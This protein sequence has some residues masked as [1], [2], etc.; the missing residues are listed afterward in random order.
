MFKR[1]EEK[2]GN[3]KK[4]PPKDVVRVD[5]YKDQASS[6]LQFLIFSFPSTK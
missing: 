4:L 2:Q 6:D 5:G 3:R 1:K